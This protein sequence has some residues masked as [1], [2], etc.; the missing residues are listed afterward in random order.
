MSPDFSIVG[1]CGHNV[2]DVNVTI[3]I[4]VAVRIIGGFGI[5]GTIDCSHSYDVEDVN[6]PIQ[7]MS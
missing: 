5:D 3:T 1:G 6:N 4:N 2:K 7:S